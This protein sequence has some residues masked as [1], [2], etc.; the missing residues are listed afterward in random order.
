MERDEKPLS[1]RRV[2]VTRPP[3]QAESMARRLRELGAEP[4][5]CPTIRIVPPEDLAALRRAARNVD[6]Y[7]WIVFTSVNGVD[8]FAGALEH[9]GADPEEALAAGARVAAIG[10]STAESVVERF[11]VEPDVV[12]DEYRAE[13]LVLAIR[14][15][16]AAGAGTDVAAEDG[17]QELAG[18]RILLPRA[19]EA[20]AVLP[21]R[22]EAA[23]AVVD[24][25]AA[26]RA[27]PPDEEELAPVR[28]RLQA[29]EID[30]LTFT[31]SSTVRNFVSLLGADPGGARVAAIGPITAGTARE[32]GLTV[33]VVAEEYTV[34]GLLEA[35]V[36]ARSGDGREA[37]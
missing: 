2:V 7:S 25:V 13:A 1:G 31:A 19:A 29:G 32:L 37:A 15:H 21:E 20:R 14:R 5:A 10:P 17:G 34:P 36:G 24:E 8:R 11:R 27:V 18:E 35:L 12:P 33:D 4:V 6:E 3:G 23:G 26:Y 28:E 16:A 30:W 9:E 22:L